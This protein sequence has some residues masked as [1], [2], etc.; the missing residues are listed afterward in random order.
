MRWALWFVG[1]FAVAVAV[2]LFAGNNRATITLF[3]SPYRVDLSLNLV[4]LILLLLFFV[5]HYALRALSA[6]LSVPQQ[7]RNWRLLYKERAAHAA[8][9]D[10]WL[11][12]AAG[13]Y[14]RARKAAELV[15]SIESSL[16]QE[17]EWL[18]QADK[19]RTTAHLL[20]AE[21]AHA[22]Q[23]VARR[24]AH[25]QQAF[26]FSASV[27][28]QEAREGVLLR[29]AQWSLHSGQAKDALYWLSQ[30]ASGAA[31]RTVALR[32]RFRA[33][34]LAGQSMDALETVRLLTKHR[35][36]SP[37]AGQSL[38][39]ALAIDLIR[40]VHDVIQ[41]Q[42]VWQSLESSEQ[43]LPE[44]ALV[45]AE[46]WLGLAGDTVVARSMLL[47][48]WRC[49][50]ESPEALDDAQRVR[51][52]RL[53]E[54]SFLQQELPDAEWLERVETAQLQQPGNPLLLY[55][56]GS[57]CVRLELWGKAQ[58]LLQQAQRTLHDPALKRDAWCALATLAEQRNDQT[59][60]HEA[61]RQALLQ[62]VKI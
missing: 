50:L 15:V 27:M 6:L 48:I 61:Y 5:L 23:D 10:G 31:R 32:L 22:L 28:A 24:E 34:R 55:L 14:V 30:L 41:L 4:L 11:H 25:F 19:L 62:A 20:G 9:M 40:S 46:R 1:L 43:G 35:A 49:M 37:L 53:L 12:L 47:P 29:S 51:L 21:S 42:K 39:Q 2:A 3:W 26:Q 8:L 36:M 16:R 13:R 58:Q 60:A 7:A 33:E 54:R 17:G 45:A 18:E 44:V 52:I 56:S 57:L 59:A 38:V